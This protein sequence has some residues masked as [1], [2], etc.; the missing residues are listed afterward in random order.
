MEEI[1]TTEIQQP[2]PNPSELK[3]WQ[4]IIDSSPLGIILVIV[5]AF[6]KVRKDYLFDKEKIET[7]LDQILDVLKSLESKSKD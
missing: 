4:A 7:K 1:T 5:I 6:A 2:F 3:Q